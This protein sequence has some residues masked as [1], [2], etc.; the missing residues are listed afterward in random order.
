MS[1]SVRVEPSGQEF[2]VADG[3]TIL[4]AA[5]R[6]AH[7]LRYGCRHGRCS[8]CKYQ[9]LD[10]EVDQPDASVYSLSDAERE[11]WALVCCAY[12]VEDLVLH[13]DAEPDPRARPVLTP[14]AHAATVE[15]CEPIVGNLWRLR[16][17]RPPGLVFYPGQFVELQRPGAPDDDVWRPYSLAT[18]PEE[19]DSVEFVVKQIPTGTFSGAAQPRLGGPAPSGYRGPFGH[20][21]L[22]DGTADVVLVATGSGSLPC[23][24]S[25]PTPPGS[26]TAGASGSSTGLGSAPASSPS[27]GSGRSR[28]TSISTWWPACPSRPPATTG[29]ARSAG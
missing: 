27:R 28:G 15:A 11:D 9:I 25:S 29:W 12:P 23:S 7:R 2:A 24:P 13:D 10:G 14:E 21:Y 16:L 8:A 1:Y 19:T 20:A 18:P 17:S 3:E 22:R 26:A 5:E 6:Q 4:V